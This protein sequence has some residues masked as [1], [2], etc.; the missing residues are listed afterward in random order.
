MTGGDNESV[1]S[2]DGVIGSSFTNILQMD[3]FLVFRSLCKL[4]MKPLSDSPPDP[5]YVRGI[6]MRGGE[7]I[8]ISEVYGIGNKGVINH[9]IGWVPG[10][11][12]SSV[13]ATGKAVRPTIH[14]TPARYSHITLTTGLT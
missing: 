14:L 11:F 6:Q 10:V 2:A 13:K 1:L 9:Y 4:S 7:V 8:L 12:M 3:A 5:K